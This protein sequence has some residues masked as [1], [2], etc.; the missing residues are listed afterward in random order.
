MALLKLAN[1][2]EFKCISSIPY[3]KGEIV[4][5]TGM[6]GYVEALTDPSYKD[7]ILVFTYPM[8]GNYEINRS[9]MESK[10]IHVK[11]V[12][13]KEPN[14]HLVSLLN[15]YQVPFIY[16]IDT[17]ALTIELRENGT[18]EG[19][20]WDKYNEK[21]DKSETYELGYTDKRYF[22]NWV[23]EDN[24][25]ILIID[26]GIKQS[27][28]T[29]LEKQGFRI[30]M[31]WCETNFSDLFSQKKIDGIF[32]S[33]GPGDPKD[34]KKT[35]SQLQTI[36][37]SHPQIP[38]FGIC[39]GHQLLAL[40]TGN[41]T[42]KM[43]YGNRGQN[44][45]VR[46]LNSERGYITT[47]NHGY[48]VILNPDS[49]FQ[50]LFTNL[51][52][53]SNEGIYHPSKPLFSVQF[54]PEAK[55]GPRDCEFLFTIFKQLVD[56]PEKSVYSLF[57]YVA[58]ANK[59]ERCKVLVLGS[60]G[61]TIGQA[62]EFDYSGSQALKGYKEE[63]LETVLVNPNIA[64][65]QTTTGIGLADKI[66]SLP[67]TEEYVSQVIREEHPDCIA[68]SYGGQTALNCGTALWRSGI[69]DK[70]GIEILGTEIKD[71]IESEDRQLFKTRIDNVVGAKV[72]ESLSTQ[73]QEEAVK[74]ANKVGYP[75]LVRSGFAL[76][77]LGSGFASSDEE[78][79]QLV[80]GS[81]EKIID[82]SLRGWREVE[83]EI[84][85]DSYGNTITVCNMEN[86]DPVGVHTG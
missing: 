18:M 28:I 21:I 23:E 80:D 72:A 61:L 20:I 81:E 6:T 51:N 40:A 30:T 29:F 64:T 4:F 7:Q 38:V 78:L 74:F 15:A 66:Y 13:L 37:D 63:G 39:F 36:L 8:V 71:V 1:G 58:K 55:A 25:H 9:M 46:L 82:K 59:K 75:V 84:V 12:I 3:I 44:I 56:E 22:G 62:G 50:P 41:D 68:I 2:K 26:C 27:Q 54:H 43:K 16:H 86:F 11:A 47:Q 45:P 69:L 42:R 14:K 67:I 35:I 77:G 32:I 52:D 34:M 10:K 19:E 17:R 70:F 85:R 57:N 49:E 83:Y 31:V 53:G 5:Q 24:K 48:E 73:D 60:G 65:V 33:N 76:G 79:L